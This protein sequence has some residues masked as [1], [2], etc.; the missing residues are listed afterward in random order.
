MVLGVLGVPWGCLLEALGLPLGYLGVG[1][2]CLGSPLGY[3]G[4]PWDALGVV[5]GYLGFA[6]AS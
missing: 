3:L 5:C 4:M 6:F 2:G 1:G